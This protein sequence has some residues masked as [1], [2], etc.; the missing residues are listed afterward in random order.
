MN[1]KKSLDA[2]VKNYYLAHFERTKYG[3]KIK[4]LKNI[5]EGK[6]CFIIG[7]GPSL[8]VEDLEQLKNEYTFGFNRIYHIFN[9]TDWRPTFYCTQDYKI[10][11]NSFHDIKKYI[12]T[13]Y[14]FTPI[15]LKWYYSLNFNTQY[16]FNPLSD[17]NKNEIP[18]FSEDIS[19]GIN[20]GNT[21]AYTAMQI[22]IYMGFSEIYLIGVDHNF[23]ISQDKDGKVIVNNEVKDYF[24][25]TYNEDKGELFIPRLDLSTLSYISAQ[26]YTKEHTANIYNATRGGKLE[27]FPRVEFD[28]LF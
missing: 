20:T 13:E 3:K 17:K 10:A 7:N 28:E 18:I 16:Y 6:R 9:Q 5:Y 4:K 23:H 1:I 19:H 25:D 22:A 12:K 26:K 24:C 2:R 27:V 11:T 14:F 8:K 21:C 15:N